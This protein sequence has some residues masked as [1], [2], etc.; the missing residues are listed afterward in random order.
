MMKVLDCRPRR[1]TGIV[2]M[3]LLALSLANS[4]APAQAP[5][6]PAVRDQGE[7]DI[8]QAASQETD[9]Q[10]KLDLLREWELK[11][12]E[13]DFKDPR[14]VEMAYADDQIAAKGLHLEST[15]AQIYAAKI[16]ATDLLKNID[17]YLAPEIKPPHLTD[18][19]WKLVRQRMET[20]ARAALKL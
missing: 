17:R 12:P 8:A 19:Q 5:K 9:P 13:S 3:S 14:S 10:K 18:D 2:A 6:V 1:F 4:P 15:P 16:A 11:Y 20:Q 7:Y